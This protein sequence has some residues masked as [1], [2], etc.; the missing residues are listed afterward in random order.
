MR[1]KNRRVIRCRHGK[2]RLKSLKSTDKWWERRGALG[3]TLSFSCRLGAI[4]LVE[5]RLHTLIVH[6]I[7]NYRVEA[8]V[9]VRVHVCHG[10]L[11]VL[12]RIKGNNGLPRLLQ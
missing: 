7:D 3:D 10:R 1:K 6:I 11:M 2:A 4:A 5:P 12:Q 9:S 8:R